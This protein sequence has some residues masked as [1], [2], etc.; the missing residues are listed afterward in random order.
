MLLYSKQQQ[1]SERDLV[2]KRGPRHMIVIDVLNNKITSTTEDG[3]QTHVPAI[4]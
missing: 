1:P 3:S 4:H 2:N